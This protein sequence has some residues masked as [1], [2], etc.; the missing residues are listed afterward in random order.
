MRAVIRADGVE[1]RMSQRFWRKNGGEMAEEMKSRRK[2]T[3]KNDDAIS[4]KKDASNS[5]MRETDLVEELSG[6]LVQ[7]RKEREDESLH[8]G[9]KRLLK[10]EV[11]RLVDVE[12]GGLGRQQQSQHRTLQAERLP[13]LTFTEVAAYWKKGKSPDDQIWRS[14]FRPSGWIETC[15]RPKKDQGFIRRQPTSA[16]QSEL[17]PMTPRM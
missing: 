15:R 10:R 17:T 12:E 2:T 3:C 5:K 11:V 16:R 8:D 1:M 4:W 6:L 7:S 14:R 13:L 9:S